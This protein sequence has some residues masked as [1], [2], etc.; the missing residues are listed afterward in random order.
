MNDNQVNKLVRPDI[1]ILK[2]YDVNHEKDNIFTSNA[3]LL[4]SIW[5]EKHGYPKIKKYGNYIEVDEIRE[6]LGNFLTENIKKIAKDCIDKKH[7]KFIDEERLFKNMLSSQPLCFNL[8][9]E[10]YRN[11]DSATKLFNRLFPEIVKEITS[12]EFEYSL[13]RKDNKYTD[14]NTAFDVFLEYNS[15]YNK[16]GFI[17]IEVKYSEKID[18]SKKYEEKYYS[19]HGKRYDEIAKESKIF[20]ENKLN[21]IVRKSKIQQIWRNHLLVLSMLQDKSLNYKEGMF[22][23]LYPKDNENCVDAI[24]RYKNVF[25]EDNDRENRFYAITLE[26][27]IKTLKEISDA[28]W[29][30]D[31]EDRYLNFE[32]I[33]TLI[34]SGDFEE[35]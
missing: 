7:K 4:Q 1:K 29:I 11:L 10:L 19:N 8:F 26:D 15:H 2:K 12:I 14:D 18:D 27:I 3:R 24:K 30:E 13:S 5:R 28:K 20:D 23:I 35:K 17:G 9:G 33:K 31:F 22:V 34:K 25:V 6:K 16:N 32:K 21:E